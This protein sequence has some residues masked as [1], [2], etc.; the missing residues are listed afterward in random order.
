MFVFS[1][2]GG[3]WFPLEVA[4]KTF[5]TIGRFMPTSW[6]IQGYQNIVLRGLKLESV[7][8]PAGILLVY[9]VGFFVLAVWRF[10]FE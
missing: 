5:A 6:A 9:A 3:A 2:M 10:R 4:G 1:A 8:L 7:L